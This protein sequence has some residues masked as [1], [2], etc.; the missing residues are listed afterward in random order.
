MGPDTTQ[1]FPG[2][3]TEREADQKIQ[4]TDVLE[5]KYAPDQLPDFSNWEFLGM[6]GM[7]A[8]YKARMTEVS[9]DGQT[10]EKTV[11][12]K[13]FNNDLISPNTALAS[14]ADEAAI[15]LL[16]EGI[17]PT[18]FFVAEREASDALWDSVRSDLNQRYVND[19]NKS[20]FIDCNSVMVMEYVEGE[21]PEHSKF[22]STEEILDFLDILADKIDHLIDADVVHRDL[23]PDNIIVI[24]DDNGEISDVRIIDFG[25]AIRVS[26]C[27]PGS[28]SQNGT[29]Y[30]ASAEQIASDKNYIP[31]VYDEIHSLG[32]IAYELLTGSHP[33]ELFREKYQRDNPNILIFGK[34][35]GAIM[36]ALRSGERSDFISDQFFGKSMPDLQ[37]VFIK[38]MPKYGERIDLDCYQTATEFAQALRDA[39]T[40]STN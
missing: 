12:V 10:I 6:G 2:S 5:K 25:I 31:S 20:G 39:L 37:R 17:A 9:E 35:L 11:A 24:R 13:F 40:P 32:M 28:N 7:G 38:A 3:S 30:Y 27:T 36:V 34:I 21:K 22:K 14:A 15:S 33:L 23:K 1:S 18:V 29:L 19:P 8:V 16:V 26:A 4:V